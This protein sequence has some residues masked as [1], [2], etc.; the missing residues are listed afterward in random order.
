MPFPR[1]LSPRKVYTHQ[2][3]SPVVMNVLV[4]T[5]EPVEVD[6]AG[7]GADSTESESPVEV[8]GPTLV[9]DDLSLE[10]SNT[11]TSAGTSISLD[12]VEETSDGVV[13][14][15][16]ANPPNNLKVEDDDLP[17]PSKLSGM[18]KSDLLV[19][20]LSRGIDAAPTSTKAE[21]LD[22]LKINDRSSS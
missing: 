17:S 14:G 13:A 11:D 18:K 15:T 1:V 4:V 9:E 16:V 7:V 20:A 8:V 21:I 2:D 19:L 3:N 10:I 12:T 6:P 5:P 22:L